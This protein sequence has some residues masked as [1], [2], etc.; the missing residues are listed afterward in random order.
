MENDKVKQVIVIRTDLNCRKGKMA[1][2]AAHAAMLFM[3]RR[4][5]LTPTSAGG[6]AEILFDPDE[7]DWIQNSFT[8]VVVGAPDLTTLEAL[9]GQANALGVEAHIM[10]DNGD[11]EFGG[12]PTVTALAIG[13]ARSSLIDPI[14]GHLKLL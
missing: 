5:E 1:A 9:K 4:A 2:Q 3:L 14:T 6:M 12:V 13:P 11:T 8:K 7:F 10:M